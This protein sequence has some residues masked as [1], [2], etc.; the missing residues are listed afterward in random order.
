MRMSGQPI[1]PIS[2]IERPRCPRCQ[3]RM[4]L[5]RI[6]PQGRGCES[7]TFECPKCELVETRMADDPLKSGAVARLA[8]GLRPPS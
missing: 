5:A 2:P 7:R 1:L 3:I 4:L 6:E 8:A